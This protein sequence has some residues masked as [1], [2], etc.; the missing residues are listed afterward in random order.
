MPKI[1]VI[2]GV[3]FLPLALG[4]LAERSG[5]PV[6]AWSVAQGD[7]FWPQWRG[8]LM[9]GVAPH[10]DPPIE[11]SETKNIKWKVEIPGKGS[12]TPV[13]WGE[14]IFVLTAVSTAAVQ[15]K[16]EPPAAGRQR[17][18]QSVQP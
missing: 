13:V 9:N 1:A 10:A 11:W 12:A 2:L 18:P 16:A 17:G 14:R 4:A 8:P 15:A 5:E 6:P 7:R 3:L